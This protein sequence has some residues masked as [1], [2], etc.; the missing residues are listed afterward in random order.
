MVEFE[1]SFYFI[2]DGD[3]IVKNRKLYLAEH[4]VAG[5]K[6]SDGR[7][8][9]AG[10]YEFDAEGKMLV[11]ELRHGI[12][13][14]FLYINDVKQLAYQLVELNG[15]YYFVSDGHV[16]AKS[17]RIYLSQRFVSGK[18]F[19][20]GRPIPVGYYEFD[21]EGKMLV[22]ELKHGVVGNFLYINDVKQLAYQ[23]V[24]LNGDYY[25]VSDS[26]MVAKNQRVYLSDRFVNGKTFPDGAPIPA[27][28]YE[29]NAD[30]KMMTK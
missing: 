28:Y 10:Y 12:V 19:P 26:H 1:G 8:I 2:N 18:T 3:K 11:P 27:G 16:V 14:N 4:F 22:P 9:Q 30:G 7:S 24:E 25:F 20:D 21:A 29:F 17:K 13:G 15:D 6:F 23:L 5:M